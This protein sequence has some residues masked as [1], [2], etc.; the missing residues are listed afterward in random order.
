[1]ERRIATFKNLTFEY[2]Y[3]HL[4]E[5]NLPELNKQDA[6][7]LLLKVQ[8]C[9]REREIDIYLACGTLLG[10][11]RDKDFIKGDKDTDTYVKD[12]EAFF[13]ILPALKDNGVQL[14]RYI[15]SAVFSFR[16]MEHPEVY[17]DVFVLRKEYSLWGLYCYR[18]GDGCLV[19]KKYIKYDEEIIFLGYKFKV[20]KNPVRILKFWY[21]DTWNVPLAK[22]QKKYLYDVWSHYYWRKIVSKVFHAIFGKN[23]HL[24]PHE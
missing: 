18:L 19:P 22:S 3:E 2:E 15:K 7:N 1:M 21:G 8:K 4:I 16:D 10:A 9:A 5:E 17:L 24:R 20:P 14:I 6:L 12:E 23:V 13:K 11:I